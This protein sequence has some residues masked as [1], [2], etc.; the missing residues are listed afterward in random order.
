MRLKFAMLAALG[1]L[2]TL[3]AGPAGTPAA[4]A[5]PASTCATLSVSTTHPQV[6]ASLVVTGAAFAPRATIRLELH[7]KVYALATVHSDADGAFSTRVTLPAGVHGRHLIVA[8]GGAVASCPADP[9]Q[10]LSI[11]TGGTTVTGTGSSSGNGGLASTGLDVALLLLIAALLIGVGVALNRRRP[12]AV[13]ARR[14]A[15]Y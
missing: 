14:N 4:Q 10:A 1:A 13:R 2:L 12:A 9:Y 11:Q 5:Y 8:V 6:G 3:L 7:T 15:R